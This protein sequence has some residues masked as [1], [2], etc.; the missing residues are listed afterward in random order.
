LLRLKL[1]NTTSMFLVLNS[2]HIEKG[3]VQNFSCFNFLK[4]N[5]TRI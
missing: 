2:V 4:S 1:L 3:F 5:V